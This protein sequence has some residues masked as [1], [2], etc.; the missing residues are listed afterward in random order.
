MSLGIM[1]AI[2]TPLEDSEIEKLLEKY[3]LIAR[4]N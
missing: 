4:F 3:N 1:K 2:D